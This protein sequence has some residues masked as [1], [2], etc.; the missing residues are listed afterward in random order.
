[1]KKTI[2]LI[3][4]GAVALALSLFLSICV[5]SQSN[6]ES[7]GG[8]FETNVEALASV[9]HWGWCAEK[10]NACATIC[11]S[12]NQKVEAKGH[13]GPSKGVYEDGAATGESGSCN[14]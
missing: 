13:A 4:G 12:C 7:C 9:E 10:S 1:M 3:L 8:L 6:A 14:H 2:I 5:I 11:P